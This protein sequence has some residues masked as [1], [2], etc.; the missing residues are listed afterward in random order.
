MNQSLKNTMILLFMAGILIF[1][2]GYLTSFQQW[3]SLNYHQDRMSSSSYQ[4]FSQSSGGIRQI[5]GTEKIAQQIDPPALTNSSEFAQPKAQQNHQSPYLPENTLGHASQTLTT[6]T[7][8]VTANR[9]PLP[10]LI[11]LDNELIVEFSSHYSSYEVQRA[12][13]RLMVLHNPQQIESL[14]NKQSID[15][16]ERPHYYPRIEN[17][18]QQSV[19]YPAQAYRYAEYLLANFSQTVVENN[20]QWQI[21]TIPLK[22]FELPD[23]AKSYQNLVEQFSREYAVDNDLV[24]AIMEVESAF[25]PRAVSRSKALGLMQIKPGSAGRDVF[26]YVDNQ[27]GQPS[28]QALFNPKDNIRIGVA[29]LS[30][31]K[32]MYFKDVKD[33]TKKELLAVA[34]YNGG[35]NTVFKLFGKTP[36]QS[37]ARINRL[38]AERIYWILRQKHE[39]NETRQYI[40]KVMAK[41]KKYQKLLQ[42]AA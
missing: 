25:N 18:F 8:V 35:L 28:E 3:L 4:G 29:Y 2:S 24:Y 16:R 31:L 36:E 11:E 41:R 34:S 20:E 1:I 12:L 22:T 38:S 37:V 40:E 10:V 27:A 15:T 32:Q 14:L 33:K 5:I 9:K 26:K 39:S 7:E 30:L 42:A 17:Q 19:R 21:V 6:T 13:S 23:K